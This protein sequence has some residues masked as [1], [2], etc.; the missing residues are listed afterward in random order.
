MSSISAGPRSKQ[1]GSSTRS[2][3]NSAEQS[4]RSLQAARARIAL[5]RKAMA[6]TTVRAPFAGLVAERLVSAGD[7]VTRGTRVATVVRIDPMRVELTVPEQSVSLV[8]V[9]QP[10]RLTV[11]AYPNEVFEATVR[12]V[13]PTLEDRS[14]RADG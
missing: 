6:D 1:R 2:P 9:G 5:A 12:F 7:Y 14:A 8:K 4:Y 3:Q 13:S 10:V 11:D